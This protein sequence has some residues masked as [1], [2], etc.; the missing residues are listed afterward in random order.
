MIYGMVDYYYYYYQYYYYYYYYEL[1]I[2]IQ[3][4]MAWYTTTNYDCGMVY[5]Y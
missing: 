1:L 2:A 3:L 5:Y 4:D